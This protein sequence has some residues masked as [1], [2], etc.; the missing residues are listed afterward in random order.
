MPFERPFNPHPCK[1]CPADCPNPFDRV[2]V[3][4]LIRQG[5]TVMWDLLPSFTDPLPYSFQLQVGTS[6][7]QDADDWTD[8][9]APAVDQ[10]FAVDDSQR[11][12]GNVNWAY[13]R[14]V[15]TTSEGTY[16]S[17]PTNL[18][19]TLPWRD[20]RIAR[21]IIR[22]Q[23]LEHRLA[24]QNGYLLKRRI[25]GEKC[26]VCLDNQTEEVLLPDCTVC[27]GT[28]YKCGYFFPM[29]CVWAKMS[30]RSRRIELDAGA[31]RG[32]VNDITVQAEHM[33]MCELLNEDDVWVNAVT[34]DRYYI[35]RITHTAEIR[36][37]P[38]LATVEMR[39]IAYTSVI[40]S[41]QI[42]QQLAMIDALL[43]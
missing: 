10:Y 37:V 8:V 21:D 42:P 5:T 17:S 15:L 35:H 22:R 20:W 26:P 28:S 2:V 14:V 16:L 38:L 43:S 6:A 36:G 1:P 13:Y 34:D 41:I 12:Y 19:G 9:G 31:G 23:R 3:S 30:P 11:V 32:T 29:A 40:Y 4:Y 24:A 27:Y 33:L 39:P 18:M 25:S 7:N